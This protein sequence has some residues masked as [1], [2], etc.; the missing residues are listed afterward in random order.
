MDIDSV[1][2]PS[3]NGA[4]SL[5]WFRPPGQGEEE[6]KG[7]GSV[8]GEFSAADASLIVSRLKEKINPSKKITDSRKWNAIKT[9]G[10]REREVFISIA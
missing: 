10:E 6:R 5:L 9:E 1:T 8:P 3:A 4:V 2:S 7:V